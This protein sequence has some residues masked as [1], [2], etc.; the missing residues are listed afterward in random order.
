M[1]VLKRFLNNAD[2]DLDYDLGIYSYSVAVMHGYYYAM[3][4]E[5][6]EGAVFPKTIIKWIVR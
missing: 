4:R 3:K 5:L 1:G 6:W 2:K